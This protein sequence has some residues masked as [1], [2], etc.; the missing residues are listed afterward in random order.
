ME[1][2][3]KILSVRRHDF[4][5]HIQVIS[6]YL[7]LNKIDR[8]KEYLVHMVDELSRESQLCNCRSGQ[9]AVALLYLQ[10][11]A[12][13]AGVKLSVRL[14]ASLET[15]RVPEEVLV[16]IIRIYGLTLQEFQRMPGKYCEEDCLLEISE[17]AECIEWQFGIPRETDLGPQFQ[18][19]IGLILRH[20]GVESLCSLQP[21]DAGV[22]LEILKKLE[23]CEI[24]NTM[25]TSAATGAGNPTT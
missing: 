16:A 3:L 10:Y 11:Q 12:L 22:C 2:F 20:E 24:G 13:L 19:R 15:S 14:E 23:N 18:E 8:A 1:D 6:G 7:Q 21:L 9:V 5:N 17:Q 4:L 25:G